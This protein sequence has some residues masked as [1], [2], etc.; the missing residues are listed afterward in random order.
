MPSTIKT[1]AS[2]YSAACQSKRVDTNFILQ[3]L[4]PVWI[5]KCEVEGVWLKGVRTYRYVQ[6]E[7][8]PPLASKM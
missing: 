3:V 7:M 1:Y 8:G 6:D 5:K 4:E 2:R